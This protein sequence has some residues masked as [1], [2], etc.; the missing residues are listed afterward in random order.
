ME[1]YRAEYGAF[2]SFPCLTKKEFSPC[3]WIVFLMQFFWF[4]NILFYG[5]VG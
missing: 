5:G 2:T 4:I 1:S 3:I